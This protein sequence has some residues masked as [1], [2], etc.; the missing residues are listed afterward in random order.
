[1]IF[2]W[3]LLTPLALAAP[4]TDLCEVLKLKNCSGVSRQNRRGSA[5][6]LPSSTSAAQFNPANVSH[7]RGFGVE[8]V[9]MPG[10]TPTVGF[11]A[12]TGKAGAALVSTNQEGGFFS[13]RA[14]ELDPDYLLRRKEKEP[15]ESDKQTLALGFGLFKNRVMSL[16]VGGIG[17]YNTVTK[18]LNPGVGAN[19]RLW[20][21]SVGASSYRDDQLLKFGDKNNLQYNV[22]Y[23]ASYGA[24]QFHER[25]N[26]TTAFAGVRLGK[27]FL[28]S[29]IMRTRYEFFNGEPSTIHLYSASYIWGNMLFNVAMRHE[30]SPQA[31]YN[32]HLIYEE[33]KNDTYAA[34][35]Y[36][37]GQHFVLGVHHNYYLLRE[38]A[39]SGTIFF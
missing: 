18:R 31:K 24:E 1:M 9:Y 19:L 25:H 20:I 35:Q 28:D 5:Q 26:V 23:A 27:L 11:V 29:G 10:R 32:G 37:F 17:K 39:V 13:N 3:L 2:L 38:M 14:I 36:S 7:D 4:A 22:P 6:S 8:A 15:Y 33:K 12:G 21:F 30:R 16:D 34:L